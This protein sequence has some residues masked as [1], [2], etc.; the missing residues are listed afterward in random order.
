M[1]QHFQ[2]GYQQRVLEEPVQNLKKLLVDR[3][4]RAFQEAAQQLEKN[5]EKERRGECFGIRQGC[6]CSSEENLCSMDEGGPHESC[7]ARTKG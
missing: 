5:E 4:V 6:C 3:S 7:R 2:V 1:V